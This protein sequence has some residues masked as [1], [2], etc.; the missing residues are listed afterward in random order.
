MFGIA[1]KAMRWSAYAIAGC[2][3][4][5]ILVAL[6]FGG[7][8]GSATDDGAT[9]EIRV[10]YDGAWTG[11]VGVADGGRS[12]EGTGI[13]SFAIDVDPSFDSVSAVFQKDDEGTGTMTVRIIE[14]GTV[15]AERSTSA[16]FG[17]VS[18]SHTVGG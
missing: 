7:E 10:S 1:K 3:V 18:V 11:N 16:E 5:F 6:V 2:V 15:V 14:D 8:S 12:V 17:T 13:E 4:L 9:V